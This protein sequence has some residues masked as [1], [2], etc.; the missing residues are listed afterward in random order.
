MPVIP[1]R[2]NDCIRWTESGNG[3]DSHCLLTNVQVTKPLNL[4][5]HESLSRL[6][7][8][9]ADQNHLAEQI[10]PFRGCQGRENRG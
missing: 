8:K 5:L 1:I 10:H 6:L 2:S 7:L 4:R 3:S 9:P